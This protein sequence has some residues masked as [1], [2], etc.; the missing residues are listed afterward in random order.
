MLAWFPPPK[1]IKKKSYPPP[2]ISKSQGFLVGKKGEKKISISPPKGRVEARRGT[3]GVLPL[4]RQAISPK[5]QM[6]TKDGYSDGGGTPEGA[7]SFLL[8]EKVKKTAALLLV[9][10]NRKTFPCSQSSNEKF[11]FLLSQFG[12]QRT[13][14]QKKI[15]GN[16]LQQIQ[17]NA[18]KFS[19]RYKKMK[20]KIFPKKF[21]FGFSRKMKIQFLHS[22]T[23]TVKARQ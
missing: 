14:I 22:L 3:V 16:F 2:P 5:F 17:K 1:K 12:E 15:H 6:G 21:F 23:K 10:P 11:L 18:K 20:W 9:S 13:K 19:N 4:S 8:R 7:P